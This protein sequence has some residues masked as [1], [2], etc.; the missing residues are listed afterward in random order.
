MEV[1]TVDEVGSARNVIS[2]NAFRMDSGYH[3]YISTGCDSN[4][5]IGNTATITGND[6]DDGIGNVWE[7]NLT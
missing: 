4:T 1:N 7:H 3:T 2:S 6:Y 5:I